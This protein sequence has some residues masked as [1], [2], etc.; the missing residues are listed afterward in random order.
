MDD[1]TAEEKSQM[2]QMKQQEPAEQEIIKQ[3]KETEVVSPPEIVEPEQPKMVPQGALTEERARRKAAEES[4][5]Q[6]EMNQARLDERLK[7]INE[8]INPP[9]AAREIP[10]P[11]KDALGAVKATA[12]EVRELKRYQ[13]QHHAQLKQQEFAQQVMRQAAVKEMEFMKETPDYND[14]GN[15]LKQSRLNE[16]MALGQDSFSATQSIVQ[17]S[18]ALAASALQQG[19]NPAEMVYSLAK[20]RGYAKST[21]AQPDS[22]TAKLARIAEGQKANASLGNLP[23]TPSKPP[24][25]AKS[26][27]AM[28]D[29]E[30]EAFISKMPEG[31]RKN[32]LGA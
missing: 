13:E 10:D 29:D 16:L 26:L 30:F 7:A 14:A 11:E 5:R 9:P 6:M 28:P 27:L 21:T 17:E 2:D 24:L 3:D 32:F 25:D 4:K 31:K 22:D 23:S 12:E 15:F 8:R 19:K 18:L 20:S 1:L